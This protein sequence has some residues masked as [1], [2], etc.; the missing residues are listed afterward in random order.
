M[1]DGLQHNFQEVPLKRIDREN[2]LTD[3]SLGADPEPLAASVREIGITHPVTLVATGNHYSVVRGHRRVR[4]CEKSGRETISAN[5]LD[6]K[7]DEEMMLAANLAENRCHRQYSD[8]E[9]GGILVKLRNAGVPEE[10]I[11]RKYM[12]IVGL[13]RSKKLFLDYM[14]MENLG[15]ALKTLLHESNVPLRYFSAMFRWDPESRTAAEGLFSILKPGVNKWR[16]L[17]ELIDDTARREGISP[18][19]L[20]LRED[21][22]SVLNRR[23]ASRNEKFDRVCHILYDA[24]F[25]LFS[26][27]QKKLART[28]DRLKLDG[29]TKVRTPQNFESGEIKI[30]LKFT[31][32][33]ELIEQLEKLSKAS[34]SETLSE[35]IRLFKD[36]R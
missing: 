36:L 12:P 11:I 13:E 3:F 16:D 19:R 24:R 21:I 15:H 10:R 29:R 17:L 6:T 31:D 27:L 33:Q 8:I 18:S 32:E 20:F 2:T 34:R 7:M 5:V 30:E 23:E 14:N 25:P 28:L 35:L 9:K 26:D 4:L 22:Q 1:T